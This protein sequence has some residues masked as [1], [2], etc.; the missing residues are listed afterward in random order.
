MEIYLKNWYDK[1][2]GEL[3]HTKRLRVASPFVKEQVVRRIQ[4]QFDFDNFELITRFN[5]GDFASNVSSLEGL[6]FSVENGA[7]VYG[8]RQLH[9]KVYLFDNRAAI[10]T[11]AN[12]TSGGL[13]N[14]YECG[15]YLTDEIVIQNLH[16][17]FDSL[18]L[19]AGEKL[20]IQQCEDWNQQLSQ[21]EIYNTDIPSLP[22]YGSSAIKI[23]ANRSYYVKFLGT[24][25]DRVPLTFTSK[26]EIERALCNYACGFSGN[27]KP[28]QIQDGD[29]IYMARMTYNPWDYAIFGKA[30]AIK[31]V[32]GR[33]EA[34]ES[35]IKERPWKED[36]PIYLRITNPVFIDGTMGDC[37]LLY[38]LIK[39]L[40]YESF[41][42]TKWRYENGE[43]NI[44]PYKSLSQQPY[45]KLTMKAVE[46]LEPRFQDSLNRIGRV[47][48]KFMNSLPQTETDIVGWPNA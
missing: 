45:V 39:A 37:V 11:S 2:L 18:V 32:D 19:I 43:R 44:S 35:E 21:V 20:T 3:A 27:K 8:I 17:Y 10:I 47:N 12:L 30:E 7:T 16:N 1:L 9:S 23:D 6:R 15:I 25:N 28:R 4:S 26:E 24:S 13:I 34:T 22:D 36:W 46:W 31:F 33:D 29:I 5:L 41:P 42:S 38:D 14:N 48:D 40:D